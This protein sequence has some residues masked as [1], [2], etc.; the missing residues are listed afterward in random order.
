MFLLEPCDGVLARA[1]EYV[2]PVH[3]DVVV[4]EDYVALAHLKHR[5]RDHW[6]GYAGQIDVSHTTDFKL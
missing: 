3:R 6:E 1:L 4:K 2:A 5:R